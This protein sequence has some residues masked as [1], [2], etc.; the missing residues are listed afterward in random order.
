MVLV[1]YAMY[2]IFFKGSFLQA[3]KLKVIVTRF[4]CAI[5]LHI[6]LEGEVRK[7]LN[8]LNH[9]LFYVHS[10]QRKVPMVCLAL[11]NFNGTFLCEAVNLGLLCKITNP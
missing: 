5:I 6:N 1:F 10:Y 8:M 7:S 3:T 2:E 4:I 11:M 9:A